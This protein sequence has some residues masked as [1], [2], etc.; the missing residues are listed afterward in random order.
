MGIEG[1]NGSN[2]GGSI[3]D[4]IMRNKQMGYNLWKLQ[5]DIYI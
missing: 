2:G 5:G 4:D 1:C 3:A